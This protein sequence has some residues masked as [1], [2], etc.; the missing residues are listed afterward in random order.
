MRDCKIM[1]ATVRPGRALSAALFCSLFWAACISVRAEPNQAETVPQAIARAGSALCRPALSHFCANI[2]VAC[3]GRSRRK[4]QAFVLTLDGASARLQGL[5]LQVA[6]GAGRFERTGGAG[7]ALIRLR[8]GYLK[9]R[10]DGR[11]ILRLYPQ[12]P[13]AGSRALMS[14]GHCRAG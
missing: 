1:P 8:P 3:A 12:Q 6:L 13:G 2:H 4:T 11:Y 5:A 7:Y 9:I 14:Y 10:T